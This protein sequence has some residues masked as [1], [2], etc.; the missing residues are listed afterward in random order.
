MQKLLY[1]P[2]NRIIL[3]HVNYRFVFMCYFTLLVSGLFAFHVFVSC[4]RVYS[5]FVLLFCYF[6]GSGVVVFLCV[7][8]YA[9]PLQQ[10][11]L[12]C[13]DWPPA[14]LCLADIIG[15]CGFCLDVMFYVIVYSIVSNIILL[16]IVLLSLIWFFFLGC[17]YMC[18]TFLSCPDCKKKYTGQTGR[19]FYQRYSE[20]M[21]DFKNG[22]SK[23]NFA[24]TY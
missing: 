13:G 22:E 3:L 21:R 16:V 18:G 15:L 12:Q 2:R 8:F 6:M 1:F 7:S 24:N 23:S 10:V 20:H 9:D 5:F 4:G 11:S 17:I 14:V 19:Y